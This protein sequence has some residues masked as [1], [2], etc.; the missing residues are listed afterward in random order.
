MRKIVLI[1]FVLTFSLISKAQ[2]FP[3]FSHDMFN[4]MSVNPGFAGS[5]GEVR[6][7]LLSRQ[8]WVG[9]EGAPITNLVSAD[10]A[11]KIFGIRS[12]IGLNII[13][14]EI[15][16]NNDFYLNAAYSYRTDIGSG[17]LGIGLGLG[18][19]NM[20]LTPT[21]VIPEGANFTPAESDPSIPDES[22]KMGFDL[23]GGLYYYTKNYYIGLSTTHLTETNFVLEKGTPSLERHYFLA[24]GATLPLS[25]P[26]LELSPSTFIKFD[27]TAAQYSASALVTYNKK[28]WGGLTY[29]L[30]DAIIAMAGTKLITGLKIGLAYDLS[31]NK[32]SAYNNGSF[33]VMVNYQ[34][35][36]EFGKGPQYSKSVRF[37]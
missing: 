20:T 31:I 36:L 17:T 30:G 13:Q 10:A 8:Q 16:F 27:G 26:K 28:V 34:F 2:Q 11:L 24:F 1:I 14:D 4:M 29:R 37:L 33:E 18:L 22:T 6:A 35:N 5:S 21:W 9:L 3:Q 25:N 15:G 7:T 32:L 23:N 19:A 12:G